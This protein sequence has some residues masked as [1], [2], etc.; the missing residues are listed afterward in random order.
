MA[1][2]TYAHAGY[3]P[4][5]QI[6]QDTVQELR[7]C[8]ELVAAPISQNEIT[9]LVH[10]RSVVHRERNTVQ[11]LDAVGRQICSGSMFGRCPRALE[12]RPDLGE[13]RASRSVR[14]KVSCTPTARRAPRRA[15]RSYGP[16]EVGSCGRA[17]GT[18]RRATVADEAVAFMLD[19]APLW[20][21]EGCHRRQ[22]GPER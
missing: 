6:D 18:W 9:P 12:R 4:L 14:R 13:S 16:G 15:G 2:R 7:R 21:R 11:A 19:G 3:S 10:D 8:V 5:H 1:R 20:L 17:T 22:P